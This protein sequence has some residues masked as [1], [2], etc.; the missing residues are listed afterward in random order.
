MIIEILKDLKN[1]KGKTYTKE[2][3]SKTLPGGEVMVVQENK[4]SSI[5]TVDGEMSIPKFVQNYKML[6][7]EADAVNDLKEKY[8]LYFEPITTWEP[9]HQEILELKPSKD[10]LSPIYF[11]PSKEYYKRK[12]VEKYSSRL[13]PNEDE[14]KEVIL[15]KKK[16]QTLFSIEKELQKTANSTIVSLPALISFEGKPIIKKQ[17]INIIQGQTGV[18]KSRLATIIMKTLM[19]EDKKYYNHLGL[20]NSYSGTVINILIDTERNL[21]EEL[22][23][24]IRDVHKQT[25]IKYSEGSTQYFRVSSLKLA[26]RNDKRWMLKSYI[27]KIRGSLPHHI[28]I[29][30]DVV[31]DCMFDFN[32]VSESL[33]FSDY[34]NRLCEEQE[35]TILAIIHENPGSGKPRGHIG[36]ELMNKASTNFAM[37]RYSKDVFKLEFKKLRNTGYT[38]Y[39]LMKYDEGLNDL[40]RLTGE[41][42]KK[43]REKENLAP[44]DDVITELKNIFNDKDKALNQQD[45][46]P[47]L[48]A[49]H[50]CSENT[51]RRRLDEIISNKILVV[52]NEGGQYF[53][54][55]KSSSGKPTVYKLHLR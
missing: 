35:C 7:S 48:S 44:I 39:I 17:T 42:V 40:K 38:D 2:Y 21:R 5:W 18:H 33:E 26:E 36:T 28:F 15:K 12:I 52:R 46:I 37:S 11:G 54:E 16:V 1:N 8:K 24:V 50:N 10:R 49:K 32:N 19:T 14:E 13:F 4:Q 51:I 6:D 30:L 31:T 53:L 23:L 22:P 45:L 3:Q 20:I 43:I 27:E 29:V 55:S 34:L 41:E 9:D 25:G 47:P